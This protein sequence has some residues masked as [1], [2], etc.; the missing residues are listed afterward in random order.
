MSL[1]DLKTNLKSLKFGGDR[2]DGGSSNQ[3]FIQ[4]SIPDTN[5]DPSVNQPDFL[6][7]QETIKNSLVDV[8]RLGKWFATSV[9]LQFVAK[10]ELLSRLAVRTQASTGPFND[11]I[12]N[13]IN[14]L[15]EAGVV[16]L[17]QHVN[18]QGL[19]I[20]SGPQ[21]LAPSTIE[22]VIGNDEDPF[23]FANSSMQTS[24]A[25]NINRLVN[26]LGESI[27]SRFI[28]E[29]S[30][31][32]NINSYLGGPGSFLGIGKTY[33]KLATNQKGAPLS[34]LDST[35]PNTWDA[36]NI[37]TFTPIQNNPILSN[38]DSIV[39]FRNNVVDPSKT[40]K[41]LPYSGS[42][43]R[44]IEKRL[45]LGDPGTRFGSRTNYVTGYQ[46]DTAK[47]DYGAATKDSYD[48]INA[49]PIYKSSA[50]NGGV[51]NADDTND[52]VQFRIA[53]IDGDNPDQ[54]IF[55]HFRAFLDS[56]N[57]NYTGDWNATKY[58]G[59]GENFYTY[60]GFDRK[61]SLGFTVAAQSK[62]ELIPMYRKLNFL[63][64]NLAPDYSRKTGYMRGPLVLLSIGGYF[65]EQ[66]GFI[67]SLAYE[68][69]QDSTW[70]IG[71]GLKDN[72]NNII[73]WSDPSVKELPHMIKVSSFQFTPIHNFRPEKLYFNEDGIN[74]K[75]DLS[76][77][78]TIGN[79]PPTR[80]IA[81]KNGHGNE[82]DSKDPY[83][84]YDY[85]ITGTARTN[86]S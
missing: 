56:I 1:L 33:I 60:Q 4:T 53:A 12:Y 30:S 26:I 47:Y 34:V 14:T 13:P 46:P 51:S 75:P 79:Y 5:S 40:A 25:P 17:G 31:Y 8:E 69:S 74:N 55:M 39:D 85:K 16:A 43:A 36:Y 21:Y 9:G 19:L 58:V 76:Q 2:F 32:A 70:E 10:Q 72:E 73:A 28:G 11:G 37:A 54:K 77:D 27:S 50:V 44:N 81:L 18:K 42:E 29:N 78:K 66:P 22:K 3:P 23:S 20:N 6:L 38:N 63:A 71:I 7:R 35:S 84:N 52:L 62:V 83:S 59:R 68:I 67:T 86:P 80:Y 82:K 49:M 24:L 15:F 48:K 45:N 65:Y 57:D 61:I 64:S 41:S